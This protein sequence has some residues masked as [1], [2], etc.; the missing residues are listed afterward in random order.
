MTGSA[1]NTSIAPLSA[2]VTQT[3][4]ML[5]A[6]GLGFFAGYLVFASPGIVQPVIHAHG[7]ASSCPF[8]PT[9]EEAAAVAGLSCPSTEHVRP[10][11]ECHCM[12]AH[13]LLGLAKDLIHQGKS[14]EAVRGE[15]VRLYGE[16]V[17]RTPH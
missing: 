6:A 16:Q 9:Q 14:P 2:A 4:V 1:S 7:A 3:F 17:Q 12:S 13:S 15:L 10:L 5:G 8:A 11:T